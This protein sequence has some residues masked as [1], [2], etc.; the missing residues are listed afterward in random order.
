MM[1]NYTGTEP[2]CQG[3]LGGRAK[4][5]AP[6]ADLLRLLAVV[7][8]FQEQLVDAGV[9]GEFGMESGGHR[10][11]LPHDH[12]IRAFGREHFNAL[13]YLGNFRST[14][15]NHLQRR[16]PRL[17]FEIADNLPF[18]DGAVN[19]AAIGIAPDTNVERSKAGLLGVLHL[20]RQQDRAGAGTER[21]LETNELLQ[22]FE[23]RLA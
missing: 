2:P 19:L 6:L 23:S 16:V 1:R 14:D 4:E 12:G 13:A 9:I 21:G 7:D 10:S 8:Q 18:A 15:E 11:S 22:L 20:V 5:R 17:S 3:V